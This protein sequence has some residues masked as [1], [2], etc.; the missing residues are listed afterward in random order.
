MVKLVVQ[1]LGVL[2]LLV[3][4]VAEVV[5]HVGWIGANALVVRVWREECW[6]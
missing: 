1:V 2:I 3:A 4:I 5:M 6:D